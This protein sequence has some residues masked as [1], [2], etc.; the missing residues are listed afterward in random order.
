[1][2]CNT[3]QKT[4]AIHQRGGFTV[5]ACLMDMEFDKMINDMDEVVI[6]TTAAWE[7]VGD[8]ERC[9]RTIKERASSVSS[10]LPCKK[11]MPNQIIIHLLKFVTM[12]INA[13]P[14]GSRVSM[15]LSPRDIA[16]RHKMDFTKHC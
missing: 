5:H 11:C 15:L 10:E 9:I 12:W 13:L 16:T 4:L 1:M 3:L 2:L 14:S 8:V 7:H 6:D